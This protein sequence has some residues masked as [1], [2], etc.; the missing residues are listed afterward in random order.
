[1][2]LTAIGLDV[3]TRGGSLGGL[4]RSLTFRNRERYHGSSAA[5]TK[6]RDR[7]S[8]AVV[9]CKS[10]GCDRSAIFLYQPSPLENRSLQLGGRFR[11]SPRYRFWSPRTQK[12]HHKCTTDPSRR[13]LPPGATSPAEMLAEIL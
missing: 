7:W 10:W 3:N 5:S 4:T 1:M 2:S 13:A 6:R 9:G 11:R 8:S 12:P